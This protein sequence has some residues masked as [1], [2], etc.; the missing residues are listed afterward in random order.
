VRCGCVTRLVLVAMGVPVVLRLAE[1]ALD[2]GRLAGEVEMVQTGVRAIVLDATELL[3]F[4][5]SQRTGTSI[6]PRNRAQ[7]RPVGQ[8]REGP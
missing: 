1:Q 6:V 3:A 8:G 4:V 2:E 7:R 5:N